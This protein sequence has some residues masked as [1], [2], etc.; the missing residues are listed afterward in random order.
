[1]DGQRKSLPLLLQRQYVRAFSDGQIKG[2]P[3]L[4]KGQYVRVYR[5]GQIKGLPLLVHAK[6]IMLEHI[7]MGREG[8]LAF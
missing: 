5:D 4:V 3:L 7:G 6:G 1:M 8:L 2:L